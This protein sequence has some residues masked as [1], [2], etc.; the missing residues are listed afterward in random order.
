MFLLDVIADPPKQQPKT[1]ST[2]LDTLAQPEVIIAIAII[3]VAIV[4]IVALIKKK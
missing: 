4:A 1:Q 3:A 2:F